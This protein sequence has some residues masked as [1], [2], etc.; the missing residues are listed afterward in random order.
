MENH[1]LQ[2]KKSIKKAVLIRKK[3]E[4]VPVACEIVHGN[5]NM[6]RSGFSGIT[7]GS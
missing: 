7:K 2:P 4:N 5:Q 3:M 1:P 6:A